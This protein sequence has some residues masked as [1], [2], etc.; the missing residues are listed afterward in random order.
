MKILLLSAYDADSHS[1][2]RQQLVAQLTQYQWTQLVLPGRYFNWRIRGNSLQ[3]A[4]TEQRTLE[5]HF[6]LIIATSMVDLSALK[7]MVPNL[8]GIPSLVYFHENQFAYPVQ[9]QEYLEPMMVNLYSAV[10]ATRIAFNSAYNQHSFL[11]GVEALLQR[12]PERLPTSL[13]TDL[14]AKSTLL[15]VPVSLR[16]KPAQTLGHTPKVPQLVWNHRWEYD[17][18]PDLLLAS[19]RE[20]RRRGIK[21][22]LHL[23][24][25]QF[26]QQPEA[27]VTLQAEFKDCLGQVGYLPDRADYEALLQRADYVLSTAQHEFQGIAVT[28]AILCGCL[29]ILPRQLSYPELIGKGYCYPSH[30]SQACQAQAL[31]DQLLYWQGLAQQQRQSI[32]QNM[33]VHTSIWSYLAAPYKRLISATVGH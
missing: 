5:Q 30:Q 22:K 17:K 9:Q 12:L 25:Q 18:G 15:P 1:Y 7:G 23:L 4:L 21:F 3:W 28:E 14:E 31:A 29:P 20:L 13:L 11:Q 16:S 10:C 8:A 27:L 19:L 6:D 24:G 2:W 32:W 33:P 26:R